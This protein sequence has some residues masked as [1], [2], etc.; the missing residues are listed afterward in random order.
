MTFFFS[1]DLPVPEIVAEAEAFAR[2]RHKIEQIAAAENA[3]TG[4]EKKQ[5]RPC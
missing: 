5:A 2:H 4:V 1:Q 3:Q